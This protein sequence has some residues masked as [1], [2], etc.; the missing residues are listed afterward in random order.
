[1]RRKMGVGKV[2]G[3]NL[4]LANLASRQN[5]VLTLQN[6][7]TNSVSFL[8]PTTVRELTSAR[9][10]TCMKKSQSKGGAVLG[11]GYQTDVHA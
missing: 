4:M 8:P 5:S 6:A 11:S 10:V 3:R 2:R 7:F 1:M 9:P